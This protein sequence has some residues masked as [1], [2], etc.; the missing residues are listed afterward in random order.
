MS[1]R[2]QLRQSLSRYRQLLQLEPDHIGHLEQLARLSL[3]LG[4][5]KR[6]ADY[7]I[8]RADVLA[9]RA[10]FD[11]A[12]ADCDSALAL[13]PRYKPALRMQAV[14]QQ[15]QSR[16]RSAALVSPPTPAPRRAPAP[17][18]ESTDLS[19]PARPFDPP[20]LDI[21]PVTAEPERWIDEPVEELAGP[22]VDASALLAVYEVD[23][24]DV[25]PIATEAPAQPPMPILSPPGMALDRDTVDGALPPDFDERATLDFSPDTVPPVLPPSLSDAPTHPSGQSILTLDDL[26]TQPVDTAQVEGVVH[27]STAAPGPMPQMP[28]SPLLDALPRGTR[29]DLV[30]ISPRRALAAGEA[31]TTA[32]APCDGV[33]VLLYGAVDLRRQAGAQ[34]DRVASLRAGDLLGDL[35]HVHG[36]PW[37]F[38]A[39]ATEASG[40]LCVERALVD[41]LRPQFAAFEALLRAS[42]NRRHGA[43]LLGTNPMFRVLGPNERDLIA[44]R[45]VA[46]RLEPGALFADQGAP[47]ET[48]ALVASGVLVVTRHG[49]PVA[50]L[51]AGRMA[52]LGALS[53]QDH[54]S[55]ARIAA[56]DRGALIYLLDRAA[57]DDLCQLP[58]IRDLFEAAA[59]QRG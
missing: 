29:A 23:G 30:R 5:P 19:L 54:T 3:A 36:G 22:V 50:Q 7:L 8:R 20:T 28:P 59:R 31:I 9:R 13:V 38:D 4:K 57:L 33:Y 58:A 52:G 40:V 46:R 21:M 11:T 35:E 48:V 14:V 42:A 55:S 49:A 44:L 2:R 43:W 45:L 47:L 32:G 56:A 15:I 12:L 10:E 27:L 39:I 24:I 41:Q 18:P 6:A 53:R 51:A 1:D 17:E 16:R 26:A 25:V 34:I 37:R